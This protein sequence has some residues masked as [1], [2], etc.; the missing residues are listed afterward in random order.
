MPEPERF[1]RPATS[2]AC[3]QPHGT[4]YGRPTWSRDGCCAAL[5]RGRT[6]RW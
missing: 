1:T 5:P 4:G 3:G 6:A 2:L